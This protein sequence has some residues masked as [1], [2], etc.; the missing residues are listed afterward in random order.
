MDIE[1]IVVQDTTIKVEINY[2]EDEFSNIYMT[3]TTPD[4]KLNNDRKGV[5][6]PPEWS[7]EKLLQ[8]LK[9]MIEEYGVTPDCD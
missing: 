6:S 9:E 1:Y 8:F 3:A 2:F 7:K 4:Y 5:S